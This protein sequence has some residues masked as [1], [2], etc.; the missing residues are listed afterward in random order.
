MQVKNT[1]KQAR[2]QYNCTCHLPPGAG[3]VVSSV[4]GPY[5]KR[6]ECPFHITLMANALAGA[7]AKLHCQGLVE[8]FKNL[9]YAKGTHSRDEFLAAWD[10]LKTAHSEP[11][12]ARIVEYVSFIMSR[13][14]TRCS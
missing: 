10:E 12:K 5:V 2:V 13:Y 11:R 1:F 3:A 7:A 4:L 14:P 9:V 8:G 6:L